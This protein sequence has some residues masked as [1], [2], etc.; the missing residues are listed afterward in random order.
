MALQIKEVHIKVTV[1]AD[2]GQPG[3]QEATGT[4]TPQEGSGSQDQSMIIAECVDQVMQI[5][6]EKMEP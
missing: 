3:A 4:T 5:L 1:N 6:R 2:E